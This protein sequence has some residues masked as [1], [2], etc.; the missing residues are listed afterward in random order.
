MRKDLQTLSAADLEDLIREAEHLRDE[1][2]RQD[3][4]ALRSE[5][6]AKLKAAGYS[7]QDVFAAR[8][9]PKSEPLPVKYADPDDDQHTWSGRGRMPGWLQDRIDG[10]QRLDE[11]LKK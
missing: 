5:I 6:D 8:L 11:F 9:K 4:A 7:L 3:K 1:K 2:V 10:G